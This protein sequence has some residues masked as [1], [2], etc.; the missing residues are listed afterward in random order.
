MSYTGLETSGPLHYKAGTIQ[1]I[2]FIEA[3]E[4]GFHLGNAIKYIVRHDVKHGKK[5]DQAKDIGKAIWYLQRYLDV[6][7]GV[8]PNDDSRSTNSST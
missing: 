1:P 2:E 8:K 6:E 7:Y 3:N 4:L 5:D